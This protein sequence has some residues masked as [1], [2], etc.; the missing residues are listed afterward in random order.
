MVRPSKL[1]FK[2]VVPIGLATL[3]GFAGTW[4]SFPSHPKQG[5]SSRH[6]DQFATVVMLAAAFQSVPISIAPTSLDRS[7]CGARHVP[8]G[9]RRRWG[10]MRIAANAFLVASIAL[11]CWAVPVIA[12]ERLWVNADSLYRRTCP[13][14]ACGTV[15]KQFFR[16]SVPALERRDGWVRI[17]EPYDA[18]CVGGISEYVDSGTA[19]CVPTNGIEDGKF[20]EWVMEQYLVSERPTDPAEGATGTAALV[21]KSD[22]YRVYKDAFVRAAEQLIHSGQCAAEDFR[23]WGGWIKSTN[24]ADQPVY[25]IRCQVGGRLYLDAQSGAIR[26]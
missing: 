22:D 9:W 17:T 10:R 12:Q 5:A 3:A 19:G 2:M 14:K 4:G 6:Q 13:S 11:S 20:S 15:G 1:S 7:V 23:S 16:E 8:V 18:S 26:R 21:G 25:F 24:H